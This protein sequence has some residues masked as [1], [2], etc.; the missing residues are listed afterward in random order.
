[1][2]GGFSDSTIVALVAKAIVVVEADVVA[3]TTLNVSSAESPVHPLLS[4]SALPQLLLS[5]NLCSLKWLPLLLSS[6][7]LTSFVSLVLVTG[8]FW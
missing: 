3:S 6:I 7:I 5:W 8:D 1:M 2:E 4:L